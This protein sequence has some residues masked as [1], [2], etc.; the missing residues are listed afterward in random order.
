MDHHASLLA[1]VASKRNMLSLKLASMAWLLV[2]KSLRLAAIVSVQQLR[3]GNQKTAKPIAIWVTA[4]P[5]I[6]T[7]KRENVTATTPPVAIDDL[8]FF[9]NVLVAN[10]NLET[11]LHS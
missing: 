7:T 5:S 11:E 6:G 3:S 4:V 8:I 1:N 9:A 2:G 10:G